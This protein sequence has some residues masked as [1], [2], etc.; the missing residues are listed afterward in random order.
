VS[1]LKTPHDFND[2][3]WQVYL[4]KALKRETG[5]TYELKPHEVATWTRLIKGQRKD[6]MDPYKLALG[7]DFIALDWDHVRRLSPWELLSSGRL[8]WAFYQRVRPDF[9]WQAVWF[10]RFAQAGQEVSYYNF[11]L[12]Q[13][14]VGFDAELGQLGQ[15]EWTDKARKRLEYAEEQIRERNP[16]EPV[17]ALHYLE[18]L[19]AS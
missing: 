16:A 19:H 7:L 1:L 12:D 5:T 18:E 2:H 14:E 11:W 4:F 9:Y 10:S 8:M 15:R 13:L 6:G 3:D 17:F